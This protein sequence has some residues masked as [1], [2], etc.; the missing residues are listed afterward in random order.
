[1][2]LKTTDRCEIKCKCDADLDFSESVWFVFD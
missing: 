2:G 1:M